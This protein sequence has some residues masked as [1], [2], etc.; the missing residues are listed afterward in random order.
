[1]K[2]QVLHV[3]REEALWSGPYLMLP[4]IPELLNPER[5][6]ERLNEAALGCVRCP[7]GKVRKNLV[8]G[9]GDPQARI[10]FVGEAPGAVED[11]TGM[12]FVGPAGSLLTDIIEKGMGLKRPEVYIANILKCRPPQNRDPLPEEINQC[13]GFLVSQIKIIQPQ[14]IVA[15]GRVAS[16]TLLD[17][18]EP[19]SR[20]RGS[21]FSYRGIQLMPTYHPSYLLQNPAKKR[22]V[23][24]DIKNVMDFLGMPRVR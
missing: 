20:L 18:R 8:F 3:L 12:P 21:F 7:L 14:V 10:M 6:L 17:T 4:D 1:V 11:N 19:I 9:K 13:M 15:L 5:E 22:D 24:E 2:D 16:Q 23:W